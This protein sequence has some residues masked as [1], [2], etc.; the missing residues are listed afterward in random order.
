MRS[1]HCML[2]T[3]PHCGACHGL[4]P[5]SCNHSVYHQCWSQRLAI[6][7]SHCSD[8]PLPV[9]TTSNLAILGRVACNLM[10]LG[11]LHSDIVAMQSQLGQRPVDL[12]R[13]SQSL[14]NTDDSKS[15]CL[16]TTCC[17]NSY[18]ERVGNANRT[19]LVCTVWALWPC[20]VT[21]IQNRLKL[22]NA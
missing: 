8:M 4:I 12:Q 21:A 3:S 1:I 11:S 13:R 17:R 6:S 19:L 10:R 18:H 20:A 5:I 22:S 16:R 14:D 9:W 2:Q 7:A 15:P